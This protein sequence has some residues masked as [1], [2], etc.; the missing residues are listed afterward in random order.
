MPSTTGTAPR[1]CDFARGE[2]PSASPSARQRGHD[3]LFRVH[4][5]ARAGGAALGRGAHPRGSLVREVHPGRAGEGRL[6]ASSTLVLAPSERGAPEVPKPSRSSLVVT[7]P[8]WRPFDV[9]PLPPT[10]HASS[11]ANRGVRR[12]RG[13]RAR[14]GRCGSARRGVRARARTRRSPRA[15]RR[16]TRAG[17]PRS[18]SPSWTAPW[19]RPMPSVAPVTTGT[20]RVRP[21]GEAHAT[22]LCW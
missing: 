22:K 19:P 9:M 3:P 20:R 15:A 12:P 4:P 18:P 13:R 2:G 6:V 10:R 5:H 8:G 16:S 17:P 14:R 11:L 7:T 21:P 1:T